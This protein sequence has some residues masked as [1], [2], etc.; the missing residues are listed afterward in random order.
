MELILNLQL[1]KSNL[2]YYTGIKKLI[3][4]SKP[5]PCNDT[6]TEKIYG[7]IFLFVQH[8]LL[9][10]REQKYFWLLRQ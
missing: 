2:C 5:I 10:K 9:Y 3:I 1:I 4:D 6:Y 7:V 8:C